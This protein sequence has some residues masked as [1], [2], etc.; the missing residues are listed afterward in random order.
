M[1]HEASYWDYCK[2]IK[3][4]PVLYGIDAICEY[5]LLYFS[6]MLTEANPLT[7]N[8]ATSNEQ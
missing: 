8:H 4:C 7:Q 3:H 5:M 6:Q 2:K 1:V